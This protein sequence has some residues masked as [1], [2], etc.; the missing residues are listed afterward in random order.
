MIYRQHLM[1]EG[2]ER[3]LVTC[4]PAADQSRLD[5]N[6]CFLWI[7]AHVSENPIKPSVLDVCVFKRNVFST[8]PAPQHFSDVSCQVY[9]HLCE[10]CALIQIRV[11]W[12]WW[13]HHSLGDT[14][15]QMADTD[16]PCRRTLSHLTEVQ[17]ESSKRYVAVVQL[18]SQAIFAFGGFFCRRHIS[19]WMIEHRENTVETCWS[20]SST[21]RVLKRVLSHAALNISVHCRFRS[22]VCTLLCTLSLLL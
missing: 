16:R 5:W 13:C 22:L 19:V 12:V 11:D 14:L 20:Y 7:W 18:N 10:A 1:G 17:G 21:H 9:V 6:P 15:I 8:Q 4:F 3:G 2:K